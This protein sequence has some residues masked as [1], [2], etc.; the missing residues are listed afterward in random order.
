[1]LKHD[2]A[3]HE[4]EWQSRSTTRRTR[5]PACAASTARRRSA[6]LA[7]PQ[8]TLEELHLLAKL[9]R[10][11][12]SENVDCRP[13]VSDA[14][15]ASRL[16]GVPWLGMPIEAV[17]G[18]DRVLLVGSFL[19]KDHPLLAARV[20]AAVKR[21]AR[22]AVLH[23]A[24]DDLLMPVAAKAIVS[25]AECG[26]TPRGRA[27]RATLQQKNR[28]GARRAGR[29]AAFGRGPR[30]RR[31]ARERQGPGGAARQRRRAASRRPRSSPR[32]RRR[33]PPRPAPRSAGP[34]RAQTR[35]A[36]RSSGALPGPGGL[37]AAGMVAQPLKAYL[38]LGLEPRLDHGAPG[39]RRGR[40]RP[41]PTP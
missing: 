33:S 7:S 37:D 40:A 1:M 23:A 11:L 39:G 9:V 28:D 41:A 30:A 31:D 20:R 15:L 24:D 19:R 3:W 25:P 5:C 27:G 34:S 4:V 35:S 16:Q 38:L 2:G 29:R 10:G 12:G 18:L 32:S 36:A 13:R 17:N 26:V 6:R 8:S 14:T 22:V 21:G